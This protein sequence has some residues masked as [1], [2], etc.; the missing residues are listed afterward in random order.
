MPHSTVDVFR[1]LIALRLRDISCIP[2]ANNKCKK[3]KD[4][5]NTSRVNVE[6]TR[7]ELTDWYCNLSTSCRPRLNNVPQGW[8]FLRQSDLLQNIRHWLI[9]LRW[10]SQLWDSRMAFS[11]FASRQDTNLSLREHR[12][13]RFILY[14]KHW[15]A[16]TSPTPLSWSR[17]KFD[18]A[19]VLSVPDNERGVYTFVAEPG[20]ASHPSCSYLLYAGMVEDSDFRTRFRSYLSEPTKKK[21]REHVLYMIHRWKPYLWF[22]YC[23]LPP[24]VKSEMVEDLLLSAFLPPVNRKWPA[25][26]RDVMKMVFS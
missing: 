25:K 16:F 26:I 10:T 15:E 3:Y 1:P 9:C 21:P 2:M 7:A 24:S 11:D 12:V 22:Y 19:H 20:I 13:D 17:V 5:S 4:K 14:P 8:N 23:Q 6:E 18:A